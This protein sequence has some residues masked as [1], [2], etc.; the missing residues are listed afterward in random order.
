MEILSGLKSKED[1][2]FNDLIFAYRAYG[3]VNQKEYEKAISD[4][5]KI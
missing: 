5:E 4:L 3:Y 2:Y 1:P